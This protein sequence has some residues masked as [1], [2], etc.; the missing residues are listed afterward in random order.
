[1]NMDVVALK[2]DLMKAHSLDSCDKGKCFH[3]FVSEVTPTSYMFKFKE[4]IGDG[5]TGHVFRALC[6]TKHECEI[7]IKV[8]TVDNEWIASQLAVEKRAIKKLTASPHPNIIE[9]FGIIDERNKSYIV[10][11]LGK[12][13]FERFLKNHFSNLTI[14]QF[15]E[16]LFQ[17]L[18]I[19]N[20]I[21]SIEVFQDDFQPQN[22]VCSGSKIKL[23]DFNSVKEKGDKY[24]C[25]PTTRLA[26]LSFFLCKLQLAIKLKSKNEQYFKMVE[27]FSEAHCNHGFSNQD[28]ENLSKK[29][30]I[31]HEQLPLE[32]RK[33][34]SRCFIHD[35]STQKQII[36]ERNSIKPREELNFDSYT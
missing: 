9:Y 2:P 15:N 36:K 7:A 4:E 14:L 12:Q 16:I 20:H 3:G 21:D 6:P 29:H 35:E 25:Y 5:C 18:E 1:M 17:L 32:I 31:W 34:L 30:D 13:S 26:Y 10:M 22:M 24:F 11:E 23:I 33:R 19:L 8:V 28:A 27:I